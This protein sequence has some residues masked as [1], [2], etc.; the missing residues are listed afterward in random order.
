MSFYKIIA[1]FIILPLFLCGTLFAFSTEPLFD[2]TICY[3]TGAEP[4]HIISCDIDDNNFPDIVVV[5]T[6]VND[7]T[8]SVF[9]NKGD[10]SFEDAVNYNVGGRAR[11]ITAGDFYGDSLPDLAVLLYSEDSLLVLSNNNAVF[12]LETQRFGVQSDPRM[13]IAADLNNDGDT[14]LDLATVSYG[15]D[16]ILVLLN[17]PDSTFA[18]AVSY[19]TADGP[20][21]L[22]AFNLDGDAI[23]DIA[24]ANEGADS[25]SL[26]L[27][28]GLGALTIDTVISMGTDNKP[29][30]IDASDFNNDGFEDLAIALPESLMIVY[31]FYVDSAFTIAEIQDNEFSGVR[32]MITVDVDNDTDVDIITVRDSGMVSVFYNLIDANDTSF[33]D[34]VQFGNNFAGDTIFSVCAADFDG[35]NNI[36]MAVG[37]FLTDNMSV[38]FN[39]GDGIYP[40]PKNYATDFCA[41]AAAGGDFDASSGADLVVSNWSGKD[42]TLFVNNGDSTFEAVVNLQTEDNLGYICTADFDLVFGLDLAVTNYN[43]DSVSVFL[44]DNSNDPTSLFNTY[45]NYYAGPGPYEIQAADVNADTAIDLIVGNYDSTTV[46][47]LLNNRSGAF[48]APVFYEAGDW[49]GHVKCYD[50]DDDDDIDIITTNYYDDSVGVLFNDGSGAFNTSMSYYAGDGPSTAFPADIDNDGDCDLIVTNYDIDTISILTNDGSN[51]LTISS[52]FSSGLT[53]TYADAIDFDSDG[54]SDLV[55]SNMNSHTI[56]IYENNAGVFTYNADYNVGR[57]PRMVLPIDIDGDLNDDLVICSCFDGMITVMLNRMTLPPLP[58]D[59]EDNGDMT[60]IPDEYI[61]QANYPNP[62]NPST[63]IKYALPERAHVTIS[64]YNILGRKVA[65]L[66][67]DTKAAGEYV[68]TWDGRDSENREVA[69]GLYLY[70][71]KAGNITESRK[72]LL[73]K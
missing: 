17:L 45:V 30:A 21:D 9:I 16:S 51:N 5:N 29:I 4:G 50:F 59:I 49:P 22:C 72:M 62:F 70:Q 20:I 31:N 38:L 2:G 23:P 57:G 53:P 46:A 13:L 58:T 44:H 8:I 69:S 67:D 40:T 48:A 26:F 41:F 19:A 32:D 18:Q 33:S 55:V 42:I 43:N 64:V 47:V 66:V 10:G 12:Q 37:N 27:N 56:S 15:T 63:M 25:V 3:P 7:S 73:L 68:A 61:L 6:G 28:D 39:Y 65:T 34:A 14:L 24:V 1:A 35:D 54:D 36:D 11:A 71:I 52:Q 60:I